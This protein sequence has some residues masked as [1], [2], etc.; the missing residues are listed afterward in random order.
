MSSSLT[1]FSM[2]TRRWIS[3]SLLQAFCCQAGKPAGGP[4]EG[5]LFE[6]MQLTE[7]IACSGSGRPAEAFGR[8]LAA[9]CVQVR[10]RVRAT[11]GS[12][13]ASSLPEGSREAFG[14][15]RRGRRGPSE[16]TGGAAEGLRRTSGGTGGGLRRGA[17]GGERSSSAPSAVW[18]ARKCL[19]A[20]FI[21]VCRASKG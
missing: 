9:V 14:L 2:W 21:R 10:C 6:L 3:C 18:R 7:S 4:S 17:G 13:R 5:I 11:C 19:N 8:Q 16:G 15:H 12:V 1:S 20:L